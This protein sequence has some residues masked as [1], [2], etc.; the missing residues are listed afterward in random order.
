MA[1]LSTTSEEINR[2]QTFV[3]ENDLDMNGNIKEALKN[4]KLNLQWANKHIPIIIRVI[5]QMVYG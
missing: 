4:A 5:K 3:D 2:I 1:S